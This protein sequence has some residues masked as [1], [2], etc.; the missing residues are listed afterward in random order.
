VTNGCSSVSDDAGDEDSAA[1]GGFVKDCS[2]ELL[3]VAL[4][5]VPLV[6]AVGAGGGKVK[7]AG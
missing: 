4:S 3:L 7:E 2:V 6:V 5:R 1:G